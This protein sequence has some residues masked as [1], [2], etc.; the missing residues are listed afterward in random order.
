MAD[1]NEREAVAED[2]D[3]DEQ[4]S[5]EVAGG[6]TAVQYALAADPTKIKVSQPVTVIKPPL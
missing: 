4:Q 1:Q 6:A 3:I 5:E 2:L